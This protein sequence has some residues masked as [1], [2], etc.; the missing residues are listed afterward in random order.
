MRE[1]AQRYINGPRAVE[2]A[3]GA[4]GFKAHARVRVRGE[5]GKTVERIRHTI[6][7][8]AKHPAGGRDRPMV[9]R[10]QHALEELDVY[11]V[12]PLMDPQRLHQLV[13]IIGV[14][15]VERRHPAIH[16]GHHLFRVVLGKFN[17]GQLPR[18]VLGLLQQFEQRRNG[19]AVNL[20]LLQQRTAL[21]S[22]AIDAPVLVITVGIAQVMLHVSDDRIV[23][24]GE[25]DRAVGPQLDVDRPE[26]G[27][28]RGHDVLQRFPFDA[29]AVF[30]DLDAIN[31]LE[32][33][34]VQVEEIVLELFREMATAK[35][36]GR[37]ART[38]G[39]VPELAHAG[40][41]GRVIEA[42]A[43]R[44]IEVIRVAGGVRDDAVA[45]A[46]E[47]LAVRIGEAVRDVG[48]ELASAR[49]EAVDRRVV[50]TQRTVRRLDLR[51][52][53]DAVAQV[54]CAARIKR[55]RVGS[56]MRI[57]GIKAHQYAF[58]PV[59]PT[60]TVGVPHKPEVRRLHDQYAVLIELET[61]RGVQIV[62]ER[63][64]LV[65]AAVV[66][67]VLENEQAV[68]LLAER[69][70]L[71]VIPPDGDPQTAAGVPRHLQRTQKIGKLFLVRP[72]VHLHA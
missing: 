46:I 68:A 11:H 32:T 54:N 4:N 19:F 58:L 42:A 47:H 10:L 6:A 30:S 65:G 22:D 38:R 17:L 60:V 51:A 49:L 15:L 36:A 7:P 2:E 53:K 57:R 33:D 1:D 23:P 48:L 35:H 29:R 34:D 21:V 43:E 70:A 44:C 14:A 27:I 20:G 40:M 67:G 56:V 28:G 12:V 9:R 63:G 18:P 26:V 50:V 8:V 61:G 25:I 55:Q 45:P 3:G 39:P 62:E 52:V 16:R 37:R 13:L 69:R 64:H 59:A 24:V 72:Q 66:V 31:A 41:L 71:R 5:F